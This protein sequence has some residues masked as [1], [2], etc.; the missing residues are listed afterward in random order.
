MH[1]FSTMTLTALAAA[2][3]MPAAGF[4]REDATPAGQVYAVTFGD[5]PPV[6]GMTVVYTFHANSAISSEAPRGLDGF[7]GYGEPGGSGRWYAS[8]FVE[9]AGNGVEGLHDAPPPFGT[10]PAYHLQ[11]LAAGSDQALCEAWPQI[12]VGESADPQSLC[13]ITNPDVTAVERRQ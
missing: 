7:D 13:W 1:P 10:D 3:A 4:A 2:L 5:S 8:G 6:S 11:L 12:A 9:I